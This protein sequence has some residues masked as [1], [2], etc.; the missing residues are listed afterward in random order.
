[1]KKRD[2]SIYQTILK[3]LIFALV[4]E[5]YILLA[6]I[7]LS[8]TVPQ[9][10]QNSMDIL[11]KQVENRKGYLEAMMLD[12]QNLNSLSEQINN[13]LQQQIKEGITTLDGLG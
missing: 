10:N 2:K 11:K 5:V 6:G 4:L 12:D 8:H 13:V 3:S 1:M 7:Y 9:L